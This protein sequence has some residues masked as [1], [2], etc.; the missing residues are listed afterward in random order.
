MLDFDGDGDIDEFDEEMMEY[1][2]QLMEDE[3]LF[4]EEERGQNQRAG[5]EVDWGKSCGLGMLI[6]IGFFVLVYLIIG[7]SVN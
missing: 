6:A 7:K 3:M 2:L 4:E 1:E 5:K